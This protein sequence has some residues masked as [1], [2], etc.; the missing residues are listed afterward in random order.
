MAT[1]H[2]RL[3]SPALQPAGTTIRVEAATPDGRRRGQ[4]VL[5]TAETPVTIGLHIG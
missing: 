4:D 5:M 2:P 1:L 3:V